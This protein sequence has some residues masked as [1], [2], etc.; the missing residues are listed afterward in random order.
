ML[1]GDGRGGRAETPGED[2]GIK[3]QAENENKKRKQ[4]R[5]GSEENV[6]G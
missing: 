3:K 6:K 2:E 1:G 5:E 4:G